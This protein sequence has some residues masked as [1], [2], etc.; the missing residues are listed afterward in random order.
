MRFSL[1]RVSPWTKVTAALTAILIVGLAI[2]AI[3][4]F[5]SIP[6]AL[7]Y[8]AGERLLVD[9]PSK[10]FGTV[11]AGAEPVVPFTV[12]N[13]SDHAVKIIGARTSCT[14]TIVANLPMTI[15][16]G[17]SLDVPISVKTSRL[18]G[19]VSVTVRVYSD[20]PRRAELVLNVEGFIRTQTSPPELPAPVEG[21]S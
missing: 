13:R 14:C 6:T 12:Q 4:R 20:D 8:V 19:Q 7:A 1:P 10:S 2:V 16:P 11:D 18:K 21:R 17:G 5:G 15:P 3:T 9:S